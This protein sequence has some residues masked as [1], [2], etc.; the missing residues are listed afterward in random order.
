MWVD[1]PTRPLSMPGTWVGSGVVMA[2]TSDIE[3]Q[4]IR[5]LAALL[6][7]RSFGGG[8]WELGG[9]SWE[10]QQ[11]RTQPEQISIAYGMLM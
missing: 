11:R 6:Q 10:E 9:G 8:S 1:P 3:Q 5:S 4:A 2:D 7:L